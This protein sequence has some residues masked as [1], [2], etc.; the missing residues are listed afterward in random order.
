MSMK[1]R[2]GFPGRDGKISGHEPTP[3]S[4]FPFKT[5]PIRDNVL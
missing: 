3:M 1:T 4:Q 2:P 5:Y